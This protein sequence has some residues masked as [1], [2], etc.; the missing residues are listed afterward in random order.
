MTYRQMMIGI[1]KVGIEITDDKIT[2]RKIDRRDQPIRTAY[3]LLP[4]QIV[5]AGV[6]PQL[7]LPNPH[8]PSPRPPLTKT[9]RLLLSHP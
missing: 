5:I 3:P 2:G 4:G 7:R 6:P 1:Q 9:I 8:R